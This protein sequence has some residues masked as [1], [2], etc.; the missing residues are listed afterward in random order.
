MTYFTWKEK[1]LTSD[2]QSLDAMASRLEE[3][4]HLI[5]RMA[6]QGFELKKQSD[7]QLITHQDP[8][9]FDSWGFISEENS[10]SQLQLIP[11]E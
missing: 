9:I 8:N 10:F 11:E 1:G 7:K 6:N 5:R 2:C 3:A 4:A